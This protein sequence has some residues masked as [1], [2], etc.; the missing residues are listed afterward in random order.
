M[1]WL[2]VN[3]LAL[4]RLNHSL[5]LINLWC[6]TLVL[7]IMLRPLELNLLKLSFGWNVHLLFLRLAFLAGFKAKFTLM[8]TPD[9]QENEKCAAVNQ[10]RSN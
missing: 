10:Y 7:L 2:A 6:K 5:W 3:C 4:N 8:N 9:N 1:Y